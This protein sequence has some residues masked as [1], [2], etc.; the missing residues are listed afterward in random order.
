MQLSRLYRTLLCVSVLTL[1]STVMWAQ[2]TLSDSLVL[3]N[4]G[5]GRTSLIPNP[6]MLPAA[7]WRLQLPGI[8]GATG[9]VLYGTLAGNVTSLSWLAP[10]SNGDI[11]TLSGGLPSWQNLNATAWLLV[12]NPTTTAWNGAAG[13]FLGTT[14]A[15]PLSI[16]TTNAAAQ[17]INFYTGAAGANLRMTIAGNGDINLNGTA[18]TP[19]VSLTSVSGVANATIPVGYDRVLVSNVTGD[20]SQTT[21]SAIV[22]QNA[23]T[24]LGNAGTLPATNFLG[25]T[26]A[27]PLVFR[28]NNVEGARLN[29]T[30]ELGIGT[31][32]AAGFLLHVGGAAGTPN[33][34]LT[35]NSG[36]AKA[37][38]PVGFDRFLISNLTGDVEQVSYNA[39]LQ[40]TAWILAGNPTTTSWNGAVGSFLGTTSSQ[41]LA[42]ATTNA[43]AQDINFYTGAAGANLRMTIGSAGAITLN[44]TAGTPNVTLTSISGAANATIPVGYDRLMISNATG[45]VSQTT[46]AAVANATS[47]SLL[48]NSGTVPATNFLGTI[49]AQ[50]L[51]IRTTNVERLRVNAAGELGIGTTAAAGFLLHVNGSAGTPNVRLTS[52][53][54]VAGATIPVGFDRVLVSNATGDVDQASYSAV[55]ASTAWVLTGNPTTTSWNGVAGSFLGTTTAQDLVLNTNSVFRAR[56]VGGAVNTGNLVLGTTTASPTNSTAASALDRLTILGGDLSFNSENNIGITRQILFR[57]TS[58][59][60]NFRIGAD[61]GDIFWQGGGAR[62]LQM[63]SYW[64]IQL[65]GQRQVGAFPAFTNGVGTT[66]HV[67]VILAQN[68]VPGLVVTATAAYTANQQEWRSSAGTALSS[69]TAAGNI[70]IGVTTGLTAKLQINSATTTGNAIQIDP[71]GAAAGNTGQIRFRELAANGNEYVSLQ[72][73]D[74]LA[75]VNAYTLPNATGTAGQVLG[76]A[77]AP[78]PTATAA[79]LAWITVPTTPTPYEEATSG[80]RNIRRIS[81]LVAGP[82]AVPALNATDLQSVRTL[83]TQTASANQAFIGGGSNNTNAGQNSG[84]L[85]GDGNIISSNESAIAGGYL[86]TIQATAL[87]GF[88][89]GGTLNQL[90]SNYSFIGG[91]ETNVINAA[92][93]YSVIGGGSGNITNG[94]YT[95]ILG[96][97]SN[98][99]TGQYSSSIGGNTNVVTGQYSTALGGQLLTLAADGT[100]GFNAGSSPMA[101]TTTNTIAFANA[102]LWLANNNSTASELRFYEPNLTLNVF[103]A[104]GTN[105]VAFKA[106]VIPTLDDQT[107]TLPDAVGPANHVLTIASVPAPTATTATLV[108]A[109]ISVTPGVVTVNIILD[110][111]LVLVASNTTFLRLVGNAAPAARTVLLTNGTVDGQQLVIRCV[112]AGADGVQLLDAGNLTLS[113]NFNLNNGDTMTLIWDGTTGEWLEVARR[114]N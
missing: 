85:S 18:G 43:T 79:T 82:A 103:P 108:W 35:S 75:N 28:T 97:S 52:V 38:V 34:R 51:V 11:L 81:S 83:A 54:G 57:G 30:G 32:A 47:W 50:P 89:G 106:P 8:S 15:Q 98:L 72:S 37:S 60:G 17:A 53:S 20:V 5:N 73:P 9:S 102:N 69:V 61:G 65:L 10:G 93:L 25:T 27:Q 66:P 68:T 96:G 3:R 112:A 84:I 40:G 29:S 74:A 76:I 31:T 64:G 14:T 2:G 49:D 12:G 92:G 1:S 33:V 67:D 111:Q 90:L 59:S 71:Y 114:N 55:V 39:L 63:G 80:I 62:N 26:D 86:N 44:G 78:A 77:A 109:P 21:Y 56:L 24:L 99:V 7:N 42:I 45:D 36:V 41:P 94:N 48:G 104:V 113:G 6:T 87:R 95:A 91:G 100:M 70:G 58:G 22:S 23:W 19:N 13:S 101:I 16:A 88:I 107:Y 105:Y 110:N 46:Y 4:T